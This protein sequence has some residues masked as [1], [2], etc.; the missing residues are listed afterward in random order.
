MASDHERGWDMCLR[1]AKVELDMLKY[2]GDPLAGSEQ[3]GAASS[4]P[5]PSAAP[6]V[7]EAAR[8]G[9]T[10]IP[11]THISS[12]A[13]AAPSA[14]EEVQY[15][16]ATSAECLRILL[17]RHVENFS[18][19]EKREVEIAARE[20]DELR[21]RGASG[22]E[23]C[24]DCYRFK[25]RSADDCADG[26]CSKW[27]A[28]RDNEAKQDCEQFHN[29]TGYYSTA[30]QR[31]VALWCAEIA[32]KKRILDA[33][34]GYAGV[35]AEAAEIESEIR[36]LATT[37]PAD[38]GGVRVPVEPTEEMCNEGSQYLGVTPSGATPKTAASVYRAM[39][40]AA[41]GRT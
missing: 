12:P 10:E 7:P 2:P 4:T 6:Q 22:R 17:A 23:V 26:A 1:H 5:H 39:L 20:L 14:V 8:L 18:P 21:Q 38:E 40:A 29:K 24:P 31:E 41:K 27:Y 32:G 13:V 15:R 37:L 35:T 25:A 30:G 33:M 36:S 11:E 3:R 19:A 34:K 16:P 28:V 9:T